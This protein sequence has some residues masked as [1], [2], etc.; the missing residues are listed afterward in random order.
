[1]GSGHG[2]PDL[3]PGRCECFL[4]LISI[5]VNAGFL[6]VSVFERGKFTQKTSLEPVS[7]A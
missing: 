4:V 5:A 7:P 3:Q 6:T 1:M 2:H